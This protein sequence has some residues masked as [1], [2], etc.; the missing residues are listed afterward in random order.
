LNLHV[1]APETCTAEFRI[2]NTFIE[3]VPQLSPSLK[4]F[5]KERIA[6]SCPSKR[7]GCLSG[8][9][10]A[11]D[12]EPQVPSPCSIQTPSDESLSQSSWH[13]CV[14]LPE[15][16]SSCSQDSSEQ[17]QCCEVEC[18]GSRSPPCVV[19]AD[20][21]LQ[22]TQTDVETD[23]H[24]VG[25]RFPASSLPS[26][27]MAGATPSG[28]IDWSALPSAWLPSTR[29]WHVGMLAGAAGLPAL[30]PPILGT[31]PN[32]VSQRA[33]GPAAVRVAMVVQPPPPPVGVAPGTALLPSVGSTGHAKGSCKPCAF[34]HS[35]GC[36]SGLSCSF[37][38]LCDPGERKRRQREKIQQ[39]AQLKAKRLAAAAA[40]R[41]CA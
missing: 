16:G 19:P 14:S 38:H 15:E 5:Y 25:Q 4:P 31:T 28:P 17:P 29:R 24:R 3:I 33:A 32:T 12:I 34:L 11:G 27:T 1:E 36:S 10:L 20:P 6:R 23:I 8:G 2:K 26:F 40:A 22:V 41:A 18:P 9:L 21:T 13:S 7:T 30:P 35:K 39:R 37:C